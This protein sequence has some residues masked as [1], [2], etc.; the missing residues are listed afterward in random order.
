[1]AIALPILTCVR[2]G[3]GQEYSAVFGAKQ[4]RE[5]NFTSPKC[6]DSTDIRFNW[7]REVALGV[8]LGMEAVAHLTAATDRSGKFSGYYKCSQCDAEFRPNPKDLGELS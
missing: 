8:D 3:E 5:L 2:L 6:P 1:M 7:K 4:S